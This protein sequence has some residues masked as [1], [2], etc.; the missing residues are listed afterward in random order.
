MMGVVECPSFT[1]STRL[2]TPLPLPPSLPASWVC[3]AAPARVCREAGRG[4]GFRRVVIRAAGGGAA[5]RGAG[6]RSLSTT[7]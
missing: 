4:A 6:R 2:L 7:L 3:S 1:A 5:Q